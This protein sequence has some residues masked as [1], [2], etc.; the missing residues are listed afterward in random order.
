MITRPITIELKHST[1]DLHGFL[2]FSTDI[3]SWI[4]NRIEFPFQN[5]SLA[6]VITGHD[7]TLDGNDIGGIDGN[8]Q[9]WYDWAKDYGNKF[10]RPM[11]L[12]IKGAKDV[13]IKNWSIVNPQF[14]ASIIIESD[15]VLVRDVYVNASSSNPEVGPPYPFEQA[16]AE[17]EQ[18]KVDDKNWLQNTD[19]CDTYRSHNV[20]FGSS[21]SPYTLS[22]LTCQK[23]TL[24]TREGMTVSPSSR[25]AQ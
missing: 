19:G 14:W 5:Q 24:C 18:S 20:T 4:E 7:F 1:L 9:V 22:E 13:V 6:L 8:G 17:A 16:K 23:R 3:P 10:G 2:T 25:T 12:A 15:N 11:S 21:V